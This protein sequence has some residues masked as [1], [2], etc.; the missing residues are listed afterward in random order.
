MTP[1]SNAPGCRPAGGPRAGA[2]TCR[3][4]GAGEG[5]Q[6]RPQVIAT[7]GRVDELQAGG[8]LGELL[9]FGRVG[10]QPL[11]SPYRP[12][13]FAARLVGVFSAARRPPPPSRVNAARA[14][15]SK[16]VRASKR[17]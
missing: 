7:L 16:Q 2:L 1:P 6:T 8:Q 15:D 12:R 17:M 14:T 5:D 10:M 13:F 3:S 9:R 4:S 11:V